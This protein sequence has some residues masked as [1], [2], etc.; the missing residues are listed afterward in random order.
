LPQA[1]DQCAHILTVSEFA[2]QQIIRVL[3]VAPD[4][5]TRIYNGVRPVFRPLPAAQVQ[6]ILRRRGLPP[7]Y[8]LYVGTLEPRKNI[9]RLLHAFCALPGHIRQEWPLLLVGDWGWRYAEIA[10]YLHQEARHRGVIHVGHLDDRYLPA[11]YCGARA[12]VFPSLY[13]GFGLPSLEMMACGGAVLASTAGAVVET[14]GNFV[15][16]L[17]PHDVEAWR[18]GM[19]RVVTDDEWRRDLCQGVRHAVRHFTWEACARQTWHVFRALHEGRAPNVESLTSETET[20]VAA[21]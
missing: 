3:N 8:L 19:L 5:V 11:V 10:E 6:A 9:L 18:D 17:D 16:Q 2:R 20:L 1:L 21:A 13:E 12:L 7:R 4:R 14:V 15:H